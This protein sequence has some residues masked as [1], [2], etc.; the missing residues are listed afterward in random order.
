MSAYL[1]MGHNSE[2]FIREDGLDGFSGIILSPV[3]RSEA[4]LSTNVP[5]FR[6][7]GQFDIVFDPQLYCPQFDR[8]QL[9]SHSYFPK[10]LDTAD[11]SSDGWWQNIVSNLV[12]EA[13]RLGVDAVCSPAILPKKSSPEY[14]ARIA[15]VYSLLAD[16]LQGSS[17]RSIM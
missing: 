4:D 15:E 5:M 13:D 6:E 8:G 12:E 17:M 3:N 11:P 14:Y 7:K 2:I 10:D 16:S 1:Q 9:Q